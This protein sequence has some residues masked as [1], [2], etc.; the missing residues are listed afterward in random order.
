MPPGPALAPRSGVDEALGGGIV[1]R[2]SRRRSDDGF[3]D[4]VK[5]T[6]EMM[7]AWVDIDGR[8]EGFDVD[9]LSNPPFDP[10]MLSG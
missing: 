4:R 10:I 1:R 6:R 7:P 9:S 2:R 5:V 3:K 8:G